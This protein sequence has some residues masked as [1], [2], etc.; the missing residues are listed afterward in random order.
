M[1]ERQKSPGDSQELPGGDHST[2]WQSL[3]EGRLALQRCAD[4]HRHRYFPSSVCPNCLSS[5]YEWSDVSPTGKLYSHT[6][7][8]RA[9]TKAFSDEAPYV[10]GLV[11]LDAGVRIMVRL[12]SADGSPPEIGSSVHGDFRQVHTERPLPVFV[13][14]S[15][16]DL[17]AADVEVASGGHDDV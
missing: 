16:P 14:D 5:N 2:F 7:V 12:A 11:D 8:Y 4:C 17:G 15:S 1:P 10:V 9:P 13:E 3:A 6:T